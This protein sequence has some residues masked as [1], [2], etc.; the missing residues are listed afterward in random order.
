[1]RERLFELSAWEV[2]ECGK[3]WREATGDV[4]EAIDFCEYYAEQVERMQS[5]AGVDVPG[6]ENRFEAF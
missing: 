1:M 2:F 5:L 3:T 6:E 4:D